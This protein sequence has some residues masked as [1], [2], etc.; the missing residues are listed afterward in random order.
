M[1]IIRHLSL[2]NLTLIKIKYCKIAR[3]FSLLPISKNNRPEMWTKDQW[4]VIA[5]GSSTFI[6]PNNT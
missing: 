4:Y 3:I 5:I 2:K 6:P 1:L